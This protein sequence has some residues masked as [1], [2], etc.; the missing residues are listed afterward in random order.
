MNAL[1]ASSV[2][3]SNID[4]KSKNE[5]LKKQKIAKCLKKRGPDHHSDSPSELQAIIF[6]AISAKDQLRLEKYISCN[7]NFGKA[8]ADTMDRRLEPDQAAKR[9][10]LCIGNYKWEKNEIKISEYS[11]ISDG[12]GIYIETKTNQ[13]FQFNFFKDK[14]AKGWIW[15]SFGS[16]CNEVFK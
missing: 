12:Y 7:F 13:V 4:I 2:Q 15:H 11:G 3:L 9:I 1:G 10:L 8:D 16:I 14:G 5:S 6:S